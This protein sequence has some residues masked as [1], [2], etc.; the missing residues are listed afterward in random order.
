MEK[1]EKLAKIG[2]GSY[3]VVFK[4]RHRDNGQIVAIKK[5]VESEDDPVIKKIALREIRMLKL[6]HVNL[7]NLL[8]VFRRKRRLHLV[9]EFC[10]QTVLNELDKH[11]RGVPEAQLKSIV[12]QSLQAVNFCHKH[13]CIH[14]DV[15]P[16]NILLTKT[17]VVK[18]C[19]FGFARILSRSS[20]E[21]VLISGP[22]DDYTDYVAT[23]WYRAPELLVGDTQYGP[24]VDVWALGC[25]FAELLHGNPLWPG[26]SDVDQLYLIR[27]TLGDLIPRHQQVF[28]S[29]IF[30]SG[31]SIPEPDTM[32]PLEKRF[33]GVSPQALQVMKSCL[34]MDPSL[35]LSC[36]ELLELSYFQE[37]GGA[38]WPRDGERPGRRHDKGTRRRQAGAQ[39]LPQLTNSNI[40]PAPDVKKQVKH[41]YHLPNI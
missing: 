40:S 4:C 41:K 25:V 34:V 15:K 17:G 28:R 20:R 31:V 7:V 30:F 1:Y 22:E 21:P 24:P 37:E 35:R 9:F 19:D 8:E 23:R 39:Y 13:N 11:P 5:F 14:R 36:E 12:W 10:E 3:G 29:N 2:E 26:K 33:H 38:N 6:K 18:L 16:E 32:E 27:K